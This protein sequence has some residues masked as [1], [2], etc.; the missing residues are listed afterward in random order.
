[1][2]Y[3]DILYY[4]LRKSFKSLDEQRDFHL[5]N[6]NMLESKKER[7]DYIKTLKEDYMY[8]LF[9]SK[10]KSLREYN[11]QFTNNLIIESKL[12]H[13][14]EVNK[15]FDFIKKSI[16]IETDLF[17]KDIYKTTLTE[18][19][20]SEIHKAQNYLIS[21]IG[22]KEIKKISTPINEGLNSLILSEGRA[23]AL[24]K[25]LMGGGKAVLSTADDAAKVALKTQLDDVVRSA[26]GKIGK[27]KS[28]DEVL[29][30][31]K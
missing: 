5:K 14:N 22:K 15:F 21:Q 17:N 4:N 24:L 20:F 30:F 1:M 10:T 27:F 23:D 19:F 28:A 16:L 9:Y 3:T 29:N 13:K 6:L 12:S 26:G 2:N 31:F 8:D 7:H 25:T 11:L 18:H